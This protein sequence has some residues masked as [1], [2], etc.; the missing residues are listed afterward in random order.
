MSDRKKSNAGFSMIELIVTVAIMVIAIGGMSF[1]MAVVKNANVDKSSKTIDNMITICREKSMTTDAKEWVVRLSGS[2]VQVVRVLSNGTEEIVESTVLP[3]KV[4][5]YVTEDNVAQYF[6]TD[7]TVEISFKILSGEV[8]EVRTANSG[9]IS[10]GKAC[11][12]V[13]VH[14]SKNSKVTLYYSTGRHVV[15]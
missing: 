1:T 15:D 12:I 11:S 13:S 6:I 4:N 9:K 7:D 10:V 2:T 5:V 8:G 3:S 14:K